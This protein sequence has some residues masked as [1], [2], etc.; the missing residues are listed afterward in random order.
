[1]LPSGKFPRIAIAVALLVAALLL[2]DLEAVHDAAESLL[3]SNSL[4]AFFALWA[5]VCS[6]F[7]ARRSSGYPRQLWLLLGVAL[8]LEALAQSTSAY[9][10]SFVPGAFQIPWPSDVLF[11]LWPAPVVMMLL[12]RPDEKT[13][14][15]DWLRSLDF[16]QIG[17]VAAT[18]YLY[19]FNAP[20]RWETHSTS[21]VRQI[22]ILY[23]ARDL[24]LS[25][26]LFFR[27]R[28]SL[29]SW[30]RSFFLVL[31]FVFLAAVLSDAE[32]L[33]SLQTSVGVASW[34]DVLWMLPC[35][36]VILLAVTWKRPDSAS[37]GAAS[38][39]GDLVPSQILS[40]AIP[41]LVIFMGSRIAKEQFLVAWIAVTASFV[42]SGLRLIL[43]NRKQRQTGQ[44]LLNI[45]EALRRSERMFSS[46]FRSSPDSM[47]INLF[48][49]GPYIDVNDGFTRLTGYSREEVLQKT[50]SDL[51]LWED[52]S[53]RAELFS[54][55][56]RTGE[57][58]ECEF[59]FRTKS[60]QR[61]IGHMSGA[62]LDLD[63]KRCSLV[64]VRDITE[65]KAAEELLRSSE[66]R[67]RSLVE[68]IHVGIASFDP[69]A[70][71]QFANQAALDMFGVKIEDIVGKTTKEVG[72]HP[73]LEDGTLLSESARPTASVIAT[74]QPVRSRVLAWHLPHT[75]EIL[76]TLLD[77]I[78][79][80]DGARNIT[81]IL[82]TL[83]NITEQRK[84]LDALRESEERF[85]T[86]VRDLHVAVVLNG[87]D[88]KI[89]FAN[90]ATFKMFGITEQDTL[91]GDV[92]SLGLDPLDE[93]GRIL[94]L[95]ERPVPTVLRTK[96]PIRSRTMGWRRPSLPGTLWIFGNAIPQFNP[97]G[98]ILRV[99]STFTDIT[100]LKNAE[101]AIHQLS[102]QLLNL[103]DEERRRIGR[104]LH[105]GLA[106]TVLAVNLSLA[107]V[108]HST[109]PLSEPAE[110][111]LEKARALLQQMSR[112]IRT[113]SYLLHPP[114][115][116]ELGLVSALKEYV[117]GFSERSGIE[118]QLVLPQQFSRMPQFVEI[119]LFRVVQ[120]SLS[121]IQRHSGSG[122]ATIRLLEN[123]SAVTLEIIDRGRGMNVPSD[124][125]T[126]PNVAH[127]GV[128][129]P[130]MRERIAQLG[131]R[132]D[133]ES[134]PSG[135][136]IRATIS[137]AQLLPKEALDGP[138]SHPD[139][140]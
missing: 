75:D 9:Y 24:S 38:A 91:G 139:R 4:D 113:L 44:E 85:R 90:Q 99:I 136:T 117:H 29:P 82:A 76:W 69:Q 125:Q 70:R 20:S 104:E 92:A 32:F 97:D 105:D 130:G 65:R 30:L 124:R 27:S 101:Q 84:A 13:P 109:P 56:V 135:T 115:L 50:P 11:F 3:I 128:G 81:R 17:I 116:D 126:L 64:V 45:Q 36:L 77:A 131:G 28:A 83:T 93:Q 16:L 1:L 23:I 34:G 52:P 123:P 5:A 127:L 68:H 94:P 22:L 140:G 39:A 47:S 87:P 67:F 102:T 43:T 19:F 58:Q 41:L 78:P 46:A 14:G 40:I 35:L 108:R 2:L 63:G 129:I 132:L 111:S 134:G 138:P 106:Q 51:R 33:F 79:E 96:R 49:N 42:C 26:A 8:L 133:I 107:Q 66:E 114:L 18:A 86:L 48:P 122:S 25:L 6:F 21:L 57:L 89:E 7:V 10:Q 80:F 54:E 31:G 12:P 74:G 60:G 71:M 103:Q 137:A 72:L 121:N 15:I 110:R 100:E 95:D 73:F 112:E 53:R 119:A 118:T 62:L 59:W 37:P 61:R 55:F 98:S 120:E 88:G